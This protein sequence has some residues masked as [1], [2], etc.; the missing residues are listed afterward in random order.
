MPA[1]TKYLRREILDDAIALLTFDRPES[2]ANIFDQPTLDELNEQLNL[3][4]TEKTLRGLIIRSAKAKIFIAGADLKGFVADPNMERIA[5]LIEK[6]QKTFD[7]ISRLPF[8]TV[9]AIHGAALGG[10]FEIALACDYRVASSDP[11][12]KVGLPETTLGVLP[13]WGGLTR[14]PRLIGLQKSL[15]AIL[16][17]R[18]FPAKLAAKLG[19]VDAVAYPE[20]II[21]LAA[22]IIRKNAGKKRTLRQFAVNR[23]PISRLIRS[24]AEKTVLA[25]TRG[26]Y[27]A[28]IKA[29]EAVFAGLTLSHEESLANE[30]NKFIELAL[31]KEAQN[32]IGVFFLRERAKKLAVDLGE[33]SPR[34]IKA[35]KKSLVIGAGLMGAAIAQW[36]SARGIRVLLKDIGPSPLA[37]GMQSIE[38]LNRE[39]V[40]R[41]IFSEIE[42]RN[43]YDRIVPVYEEVPLNDIDLVIEAAVE[44][45]ELKQKIFAALEKKVSPEV[46]IASNTSALSIDAMAASLQHPERLVGIH[47]FNPVHRMQLVEIVRGPKTS[48]RTAETA[49]RF[50]KD[51]GKLPVLVRDSPGFLVNRILLPYLVEAMRLFREG[52]RLADIDGVM[53]DFGM[54]MGAL[55][56]IDEVGFDVAAHVARELERRLSYLGP[57][58]D[59]LEKMMAKGWLGR[60]SAMGFYRY[61][62][63][64]KESP[65]PELGG[66]QATAP[67]VQNEGDLR[68][69]LV[70]IMVNEAA[71]TLEEKVVE[72]PE[73]VDFGMVMGTG[74]APFRGGPLRFA[75]TLG[76]GT[77]AS[78]LN[79]LRERIGERFAPCGL[80]ATMAEKGD[81]FYPR[82]QVSESKAD[83]RKV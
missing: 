54:P 26:N 8:V 63:N 81:T 55:R 53:L 29:L 42:A 11:A 45:I 71:R 76:L 51:I 19:M 50:T 77:V 82:D 67:T 49:L 17:G 4:E 13:A 34:P 20:R 6:G 74:W 60:K 35:V 30:K 73:D 57:L 70:L 27:P 1:A 61:G 66:F 52:H 58:D 44:E 43:A 46:V 56:L 80:L 16:T 72:A 23:P 64:G 33:S 79:N 24:E 78:R 12:T 32:L 18:Q 3:L 38:K 5:F 9:A 21:D 7:R 48:A 25:K 40:R 10:G 83:T 65:N 68:D 41:R 28:Q 62:P 15:D 36:L 14:L 69:R 22:G 37:K 47:F 31:G 2:I 39:A 75:D 59:T